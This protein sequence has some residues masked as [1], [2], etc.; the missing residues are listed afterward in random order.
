MKQSNINHISVAISL[1]TSSPIS[2]GQSIPSP[3]TQSTL[4]NGYGCYDVDDP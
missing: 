3:F 2:K 1:K 4:N